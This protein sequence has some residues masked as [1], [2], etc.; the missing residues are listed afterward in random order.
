LRCL[1]TTISQK[2]RLI[3]SVTNS[4]EQWKVFKM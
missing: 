3:L 2:T 4:A 1:T